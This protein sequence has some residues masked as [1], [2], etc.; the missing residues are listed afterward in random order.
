MAISPDLI[1]DVGLHK[2][3]DAEFYLRK[4]FRV[5][6]LAAAPALCEATRARLAPWVTSH[7]LE[8]V[9]RA[10][11]K[12]NDES[13]TFYINPLKDDWGSTIRGAAEKG[14]DTVTELTVQSITLATLLDRFG[15]PH[16]LKSDIEG[17]DSL[18]VR[19]LLADDRRPEFV[20][21]EATNPDD[22]D[23][24]RECGYTS[25]QLINQWMNPFTVCPNPSR[26]GGFV[27]TKFN[28]ETSGL[29]GNDLDESRW[30]S[31]A[32]AKD[33]YLQWR[34]LHSLDDKLAPGWLDVH[35]RA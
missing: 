21:I 20:S 15:V 24:L 27:E 7:R 34:R 30:I 9:N 33:R 22:F 19:Q 10:L 25:A 14:Q 11:Y 29:F 16:S 26:E 31:I 18:L 12:R 3:F 23:V 35:V 5:V 13:V 1:F 32:E 8:I 17:G 2:G 4:G 6:G 28:G